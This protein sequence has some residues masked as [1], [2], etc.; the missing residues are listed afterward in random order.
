MNHYRI[1][2]EYCLEMGGVQEEQPHPKKK[3]RKKERQRQDSDWDLLVGGL[4]DLNDD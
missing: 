2:I 4:L 3:K 1:R